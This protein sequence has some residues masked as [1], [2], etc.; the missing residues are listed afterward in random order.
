MMSNYPIRNESW[1]INE[2]R[3]YCYDQDE[4]AILTA[5]IQRREFTECIVCGTPIEQ[6]YGGR[7]RRFCERPRCRKRGNRLMRRFQRWQWEQQTQARLLAYW[8]E[9]LP[10]SQSQLGELLQSRWIT[11]E[12]Q[13]GTSYHHRID[14]CDHV[15]QIIDAERKAAWRRMERYTVVLEQRAER[16]EERVA[17]LEAELKQLRL[18]LPGALHAEIERQPTYTRVIESQPSNPHAVMLA[19]SPA[20]QPQEEDDDEEDPEE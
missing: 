18:L 5:M 15:T 11:T 9:L 14:V 8:Q 7:I 12:S 20:A 3:Q 10:D 2:Y 16:A 1:G 4:F 13:E 6:P 17:E 19:S